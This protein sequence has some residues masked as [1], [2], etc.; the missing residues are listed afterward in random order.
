M[1]TREVRRDKVAL[2]QQIVYFVG[3]EMRENIVGGYL[4]T[5][6]QGKYLDLRET[7]IKGIC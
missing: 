2:K 5:T 7:K 6:C 1:R 4:E 3:E